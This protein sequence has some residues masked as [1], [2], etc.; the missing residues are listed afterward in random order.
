[1][2][3]VSA[4]AAGAVAEPEGPGRTD[5]R[6]RTGSITGPEMVLGCLVV[7]LA[8]FSWMALLLLDNHVGRLSLVALASAAALAVVGAVVFRYRSSIRVAADPWMWA[9]LAVVGGVAAWL[10]IPGDPYGV[11]DKDPGAYVAIGAAFARTHSYSFPDV[12]AQHLT[13]V[14]GQSPGVRFPAVWY[15]HGTVIVPQFYHLWPAL[16]AM[17]NDVGG[18]RLETQMAPVIGVL[19]VCMLAVLTRR[20]VPGRAG[21]AAA[22]AAGLLLETNMM[23]TWQARYPSTEVLAQLLFLT[24]L[25]ALC[26][27]ISTGWRP[28]AGAAGL[29]LGVAWLERPDAVVLV[30]LA[31]GAGAV[32]VAL[33]RWDG[34]A[35]WFLAGFGV[36]APHALWQVYAGAHN[37]SVANTI[38]SGGKLVEGS[39]ALLVAALVIR[40]VPGVASTLTRWAATRRTQLAA[41]LAVLAVAAGLVVLGFLRPRLFGADIALSGG[42]PHRTLNE[43]SMRRLS[44]FLTVPAFGLALAG[45]ATV[46]LRRWRLVAWITVLPTV[47][48]APLYIYNARITPGVMWWVR[49]YVPEVLPGIILL[50]A[51]AVAFGLAY[52]LR[53]RPVLALPA[54]AAVV[55]LLVVFLSQSV[56]LRADHE[57]AGSFEVTA[58]MAALAGPTR[59]VYLFGQTGCC[60]TPEYLFGG[61]LWLERDQYDAL[62]PNGPA[63][64][65]YIRQAQAAM[66]GHPVFV[67]WMGTGRP[68]LA[69]LGLT[70]VSHITASLPRW[71]ETLFSRPDRAAPPVAVDF[72]VWRVTA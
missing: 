55:A 16:L 56:P 34:R 68:P 38:P 29:L 42:A 5:D 13:G 28:A 27:T 49:R 25:L 44:W 70:A 59:G 45:L 12:L 22:L 60:T 7:V 47:I 61:A 1:M 63:A 69:P 50:I 37:Y 39:A 30:G 31:A 54:V 71:E 11:T 36:V 33:R 57:N 64:V 20:L 18:L 23:Q 8:V 4:P 46:A 3:T 14:V 43:Q 40:A 9:V 6:E 21:L 51:L 2:V 72:T 48:V 24:I 32:L 19:A 17:A 66:P 26:V 67:V 15:G 53:G 52:R 62:M 58:R 41:G 10:Y 65:T 35:W